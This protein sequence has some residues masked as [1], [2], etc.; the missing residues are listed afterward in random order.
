MNTTKVDAQKFQ[1]AVDQLGEINPD[2][3]G[4]LIRLMEQSAKGVADLP[5]AS[6]AITA[7][8]DTEIAKAK[9]AERELM[10]NQLLEVADRI[11][12]VDPGGYN[13][14]LWIILRENNDLPATLKADTE[15]NKEVVEVNE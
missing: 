5:Q 6:L 10:A 7:L 14:M 11:E 13:K 3:L 9:K 1:E 4:I 12:Y 8:L 2:L 15:S